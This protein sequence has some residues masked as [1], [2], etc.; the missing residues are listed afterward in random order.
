MFA[1]SLDAEA[2]QRAVLLNAPLWRQF[3]VQSITGV[4]RSIVSF[5]LGFTGIRAHLSLWEK[6]RTPLALILGFHLS[7]FH[8]V[9]G[10]TQSLETLFYFYFF[11]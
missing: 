1:D 2:R 5:G 8:V 10:C 9:P 6:L 7:F 11:P 4:R 3:L